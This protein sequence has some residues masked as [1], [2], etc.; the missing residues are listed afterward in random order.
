MVLEE[1]IKHVMAHFETGDTIVIS[2]TED[3]D[4]YT[5]MRKIENDKIDHMKGYL[6][7]YQ[8]YGFIEDC[9]PEG[10]W[11]RFVDFELRKKRSC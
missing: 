5:K 4:G 9:D 10:V 11:F 7:R 8:E 6:R 2:F 1:K 3:A